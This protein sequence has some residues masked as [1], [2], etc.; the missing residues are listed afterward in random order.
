MHMHYEISQ[1]LDALRLELESVNRSI[2]GLVEEV[3]AD[4]AK[5]TLEG[6]RRCMAVIHTIYR[7]VDMQQVASGTDLLQRCYYSMDNCQKDLEQV[8][9]PFSMGFPVLDTDLKQFALDWMEFH[10]THLD[11]ADCIQQELLD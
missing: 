4:G 10:Q 7:L 9:G 3:D 8:F 11:L 2:G 6:V 1:L 5:Q